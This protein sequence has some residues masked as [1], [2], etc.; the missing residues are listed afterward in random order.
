MNITVELK[1]KDENILENGVIR[2]VK[3]DELDKVM[4]LQNKVVEWLPKKDLYHPTSKESFMRFTG[5]MGDI[6]G[7]FNYKDE[8]IGI[9]VYCKLGESEENYGHDINIS[10]ED[11]LKVAQIEST[12][13]HKSYRGNKLQLKICEILEELAI[14]DN[15]KIIMSTVSPENPHSLNSF[16]NR[17][18]KI[19]KEKEK[20][21]GLRRFILSKR[22]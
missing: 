4:E 12:L 15:M 19:E 13:V 5:R 1:N 10:G 14:K 22:L 6:V 21:G 7:C 11:L 20:Y 16:L 17:D 18:Y 2:L 3:E 8:L 9:G